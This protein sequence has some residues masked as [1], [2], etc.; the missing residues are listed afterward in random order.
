[1]SNNNLLRS[2][3]RDLGYFFIGVTLI[4]A[5]T[6]FILSARGLGWFKEEYSFKTIITQNIAI[7]NFQKVLISEAKAGKLNY[8]YTTETK[9]VVERNI[10]RLV[11][12]KKENNTLYFEYKTKIRIQYNITSGVVDV[13]Y[14]AYPPYLEIFISSHL[15]T[16]NYI[17][18][19]L[20]MAYSIALAFFAISGIFIVKGKYGFKKRGIYLTT[21]GILTV[22]V[23]IYFS[24]YTN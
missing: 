14:K 13:Y 12:T 16:N 6:G 10:K 8:I 4:Y 1:M 7:E 21:M 23:F 18:F 22:F 11:F 24:F 2:L 3:H 5:I 15:S 19:Y 9:K 20:A 17:W